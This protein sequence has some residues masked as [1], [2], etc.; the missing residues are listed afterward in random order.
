MGA[1]ALPCRLRP[2][3][4]GG[5][6]QYR[7]LRSLQHLAASLEAAEEPVDPALSAGCATNGAGPPDPHR[8]QKDCS[9]RW[10]RSRRDARGRL[11]PL[12]GFRGRN[13]GR[14]RMGVQIKIWG[15]A[16]LTAAAG[17][18]QQTALHEN[19][20]PASTTGC[21]QQPASRKTARTGSLE[22]LAVPGVEN[23]AFGD[24]S[25][26]DDGRWGR[27]PMWGPPRPPRGLS[28]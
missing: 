4:R 17:C 1:T 3:G 13:G 7:M 25:P 20:T 5:S 12:R 21:V 24:A 22:R 11:Q 28:D 8:Q 9:K 14:L 23:V 27:G 26:D 6:V 2:K 15:R 18:V 16:A 19:L 10:R